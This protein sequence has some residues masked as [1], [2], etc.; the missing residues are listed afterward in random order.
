MIYKL[1]QEKT[2]ASSL[3]RKQSY[4]IIM[5]LRPSAS[6]MPNTFPTGSVSIINM[7]MEINKG[8]WVH[9]ILVLAMWSNFVYS[10]C[11]DIVDIDQS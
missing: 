2:Y 11:C 3:D 9:V 5:L 4:N 7:I 10:C 1:L 6:K 8:E